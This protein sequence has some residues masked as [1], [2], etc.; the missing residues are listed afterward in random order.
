[1]IAFVSD[2]A[3]NG[4]KVSHLC[5]DGGWGVNHVVILCNFIFDIMDYLEVDVGIYC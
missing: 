5:W 4:L 1:M 2:F 3:E